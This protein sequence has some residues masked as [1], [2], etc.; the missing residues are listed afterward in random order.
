[1]P[2]RRQQILFVS[3]DI[4]GSDM[5]G[6]GIRAWEL[7][8]ALAARCVVTLAAPDS[9]TPPH[10]AAI[11]VLPYR[12]GQAGALTPALAAADVVVGQGFVFERQPELLACDLP[13]AIDLYDPLIIEGLDLYASAELAVAEAQ[14][15]RYQALTEA[16][17]RRGDFFFCATEPQRDY[18][19]GA[20]TGV[21]RINP[22][23]VRAADRELHQVIGL[24]PSGIASAPPAAASPPALRGTHPALGDD[25]MIALWAGGLWEWFDPQLLVRAV[26]ALRDACPRLRLV[27]FAGARPNPD[28]PPIT[29]RLRAEA[30]ACAAELGILDQSVIFLD[31]WVPYAAR[32]AL[33]AEA[34]I[35]VSAHLPGIETHFAFRTRL[36]DYLWARLPVLCTAGDS[37]GAAF[38]AAGCARQVPPYDLAGWAAAFR[39]LYEQAETRQAMRSAAHTLAEQWT[40]EKAAQP[41]LTFCTS[42]HRLPAITP[43]ADARAAELEAALA[44]RG[45]YVAHVEH[46]YQR[47]VAALHQQQRGIMARLRQ[48]LRAGRKHGT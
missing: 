31:R 35:G 19:L 20:L 36:L 8:H 43:A 13:L 15:V 37:L 40:W 29:T 12:A 45:R 30:E 11:R 6:P 47:A 32:G 44:E 25:A 2:E 22:A 23:V 14:H 16:Q 48:R 33:L 38:A 42:P 5:A 26:A 18:W 7:A 4:I 41:L 1:M 39:Q 3:T 17:L 9:A 34:D 24:V 46:E 21:G 27:F 28:G 10:S